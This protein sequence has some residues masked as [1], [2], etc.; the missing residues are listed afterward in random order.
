MSIACRDLPEP[1]LPWGVSETDRP[2][3]DQGDLKGV[4]MLSKDYYIKGFVDALGERVFGDVDKAVLE[5]LQELEKSPDPFLSQSN[6]SHM[7]MA[8]QKRFIAQRNQIKKEYGDFLKHLHNFM[9]DDKTGRSFKKN[10]FEYLAT[11]FRNIAVAENPRCIRYLGM[12]NKEIEINSSMK[13][14]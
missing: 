7:T 2:V 12:V 3:G 5:E 4:K 13:K 11:L 1:A 10:E 9:V 8:E 14:R 6:L